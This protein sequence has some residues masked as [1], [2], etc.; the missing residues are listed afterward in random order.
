LDEGQIAETYTRA[1][2][3]HTAG[4]IAEAYRAYWQVLRA[5]PCRP[6]TADERAMILRHAPRVFVTP[7]E[8]FPLKDAAAILHP[9]QP[10]I[11]YHF[12]WEDDIDFP[13][14]QEPCDH[15]LVWVRYAPDGLAGVHTY[16]HNHILSAAEAVAEALAHGGC[17]RIN[18]QWGKH[19]S[20]PYAWEKIGDGWLLADVRASYDRLHTTGRRELDNPLTRGWPLRYEGSWEAF[21]DFSREVDL[22]RFLREED[23]LMV[24]RWSNAVI[25][26]HFLRYNFHPKRDWPETP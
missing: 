3:L 24:S 19:G 14:D 23:L 2:E 10:L 25:N 20:L 8:C 15:E 17:P 12:F 9:T 1:V 22:S 11:A 4:R 13:D 6:P 26:T 16:Y 7:D 18:V 21:T 5:D